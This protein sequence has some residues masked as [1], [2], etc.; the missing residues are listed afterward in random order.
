MEHPQHETHTV[1][2][3]IMQLRN[4]LF[5]SAGAMIVGALIAHH[6]NTLITHYVLSPAHGQKLLF[7]SPLEPLFFVIKIDFLGG[8]VLAFPFILWAIFSYVNPAISK[9]SRLAIYSTSII[10]AILLAGGILYSYLVTI[11]MTM[12]FLMSI[13]IP[14]TETTITAESYLGFFFTQMIIIMGIFQVPIVIING[15]IMRIFTVRQL[16][17]KRRYVYIIVTTALA[18]ITPTTDVFSLAIVLVPTLAIFELS[19][20]VGWVFRLGKT[21]DR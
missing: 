10:S 6:Y 7:L 1:I 2:D 14:G 5:V 12:K 17:S 18:I 13:I 4:K 9:R 11:P 20:L 15:F 19:L 8:T 21:K 16:S 3:H